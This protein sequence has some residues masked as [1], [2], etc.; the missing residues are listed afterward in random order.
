MFNSKKGQG[1]VEYVLIVAL[2]AGIA[3]AVI[4]TL[5]S[6]TQS[7]FSKASDKVKDAGTGW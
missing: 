7:N 5:G 4:K 6:N 2:L 1:I 3:Y